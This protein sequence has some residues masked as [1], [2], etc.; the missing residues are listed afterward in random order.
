[1]PDK[2]RYLDELTVAQNEL[3]RLIHEAR[4]LTVAELSALTGRPEQSVRNELK[5][6][7]RRPRRLVYIKEWRWVALNKTHRWVQ[8]W[9]LG[10]GSDAPKPPR[11]TNTARVQRYDA[12]CRAILGP[13][14]RSMRQ[15]RRLVAL[16]RRNSTQ[17]ARS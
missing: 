13:Q 2:F 8:V 5:G 7:F 10:S 6:P 3:R 11:S 16:I 15:A 12:K 17:G 14:Y 9:G 4:G 1:M